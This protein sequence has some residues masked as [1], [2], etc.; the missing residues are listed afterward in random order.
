MDPVDPADRER[1]ESMIRDC[2]AEAAL[3]AAAGNPP[4]GAVLCDATGRVIARGH[5]TQV[6]T[7]DPTAH[8]EVNVLRAG[9][10]ARRSPD[11]TGWRLYSNAE[12]CS[13]CMSAIVKAGIAEV[14]YGAP[15]EPHLDPYLPA[16]D[17]LARAA[18]P[19]RVRPGVL[20][21]EAAAQIARARAGTRPVD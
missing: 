21:A 16:A 2:M 1:D 14:T 9:G 7:N 20:A 13:M 4:F 5:N 15:H 10:L 3:A 19:P 11:L 8:G 18:H 6:S 17:V 12:P